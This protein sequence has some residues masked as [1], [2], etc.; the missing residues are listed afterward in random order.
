MSRAFALDFSKYLLP[1]HLVHLL[2][3]WLLWML[4]RR[5]GCSMFAASAGAL[6]SRSSR[7]AVRS[8]TDRAFG[9]SG[10]GGVG[11]FFVVGRDGIA[12]EVAIGG[13]YM[14]DKTRVCGAC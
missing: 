12:P 6:F 1:L 8:S 2:N 7:Y 9:G 14:P 5:L 10:G 13:S 3:V 11:F 4:L